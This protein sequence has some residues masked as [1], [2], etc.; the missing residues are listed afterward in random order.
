MRAREVVCFI[1]FFLV[2]VCLSGCE[3][4]ES[5]DSAD[6]GFSREMERSGASLDEIEKFHLAEYR[7]YGRRPTSKRVLPE[8]DLKYWEKYY[9]VQL[10][11]LNKKC[12]EEAKK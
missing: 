11:A 8:A 2:V 10:W 1:V 4:E 9:E 6:V 3:L 5:A 7:K 12:R